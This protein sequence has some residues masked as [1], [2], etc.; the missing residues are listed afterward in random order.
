MSSLSTTLLIL[1]PSN[2]PS[3]LLAAPKPL[4]SNKQKQITQAQHSDPVAL[5]NIAHAESNTEFSKASEQG[6][7][8]KT[9][10]A[11]GKDVDETIEEALQEHLSAD[12]VAQ[13]SEAYHFN[14]MA[15]Y[16]HVLAVHADVA[17]RK[18]R[19]WDEVE[20]NFEKSSLMDVHQEDLLIL[21][22]P[23]FSLKDMPENIMLKPTGI[24]SS[25]KRQE[26]VVQQRWEVLYLLVNLI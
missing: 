22:P 21:V 16:Q 6:N 25:K 5:A 13:V 2:A 11:D 18:K 24:L 17:R 20:P 12:I 4:S 7:E 3:R 9:L 1:R 15:D 19:N 26:G 14:G 10:S 23:F 8:F